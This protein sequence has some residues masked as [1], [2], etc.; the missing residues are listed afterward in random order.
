MYEKDLNIL[1]F[2]LLV[3]SSVFI[4]LTLSERTGFKVHKKI[5]GSRD[6][7]SDILDKH[8]RMRYVPVK[9]I[10]AGLSLFIIGSA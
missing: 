5:N 10:E 3:C 2:Y 6:I 9:A 8:P 4:F 1:A 7:V